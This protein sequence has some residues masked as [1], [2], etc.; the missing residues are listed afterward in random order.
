MAVLK[1]RKFSGRTAIED[2][3]EQVISPEQFITDEP[4]LL[5]NLT[6]E[7]EKYE[8]K[9]LTSFNRRITAGT[10][11]SITLYNTALLKSALLA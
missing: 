6:D 2:V 4:P 8:I 3:S 11:F 9:L 1:S 7:E 10:P 5:Q